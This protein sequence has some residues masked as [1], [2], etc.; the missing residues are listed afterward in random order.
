MFYECY[1]AE[2]GKSVRSSHVLRGAEPDS[3]HHRIC[4]H[5]LRSVDGRVAVWILGG[6]PDRGMDTKRASSAMRRCGETDRDGV[7]IAGTECDPD[8]D[9]IYDPRA[10]SGFLST[11]E[12][13][14]ER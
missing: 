12:S 1:R 4:R 8:W 6:V 2:I 5:R 10:A 7:C 13:R 11:Y 9:R 3:P 14:I